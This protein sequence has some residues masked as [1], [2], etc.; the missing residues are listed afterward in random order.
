MFKHATLTNASIGELAEAW[1]RC[2]QG[3]PYEMNFTE[4]HMKAWLYH[5]QVDLSHSIVLFESGKIVGFSLLALDGAE[6]WIAGTSIDPQFRGK[7][8]FAPLMYSQ[9]NKARDL[10]LQRISLEVLTENHAAKVYQAVGFKRFR[11]LLSYRIP[12]ETLSPK[13]A[14]R[15]LRPF[16]EVSLKDYFEARRHAG[17][18][19]V[20]QRRENCLRNYSPLT[21]WLD[22]GATSGILLTGEYSTLLVDT[23]T[24]SLEQSEHL[25]TSILE[26]TGGEF[27][28]KNQ[29]KDWFSAFLTQ[30]RIFPTSIQYEMIYF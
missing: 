22:L 3:Y 10:G 9:V 14:R 13:H 24:R 5:M 23:W 21:A 7:H 20:W 28:L 4:A 18:S 25:F 2:W 27:T 1:N 26:K 30:Q 17:F 6:G 12:S 29:P 15:V 16:H 11:E 19:P 8:L